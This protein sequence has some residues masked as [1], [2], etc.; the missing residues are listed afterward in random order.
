LL[1]EALVHGET[2]PGF[3]R[4]ERSVISQLGCLE[5][6]MGNL[7][8]A[9]AHYERSIEAYRADNEENVAIHLIN[10]AEALL[11]LARGADALAAAQ[12]ALLHID[13]QPTLTTMAR[14]FS[15]EAY[16]DLGHRDEALRW[17]DAARSALIHLVVEDP[18]L[19]GYLARI[20]AI[21]ARLAPSPSLA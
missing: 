13:G 6:I 4:H 7:D 11:D 15:G 19:D 14:A 9:V 2:L 16:A 18:T 12:E 5:H 20:T 1:Q 3:A 17:L 8:V 21:Q 10:K